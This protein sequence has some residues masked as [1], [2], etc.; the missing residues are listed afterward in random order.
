MR[1]DNVIAYRFTKTENC[2][3]LGKLKATGYFITKIEPFIN[4]N[5]LKGYSDDTSENSDSLKLR[6]T[7]KKDFNIRPRN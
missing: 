1:S 3:T 5:N 7:S 2:L 6:W 4:F